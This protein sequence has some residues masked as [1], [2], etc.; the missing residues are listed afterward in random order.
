MAGWSSEN[1]LSIIFSLFF[2]LNGESSQASERAQH[3]CPP[4]AV[5]ELNIGKCGAARRRL[6]STRYSGDDNG[7]TGLQCILIMV[8]LATTTPTT[9]H[10]W[11]EPNNNALYVPTS[12]RVKWRLLKCFTDPSDQW[13]LK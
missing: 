13:R 5:A 4:E 9:T 3:S 1:T 10:G 8:R 6:P 2:L 11:G 12:P 7:P